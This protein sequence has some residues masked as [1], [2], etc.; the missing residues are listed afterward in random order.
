MYTSAAASWAA[1]AASEAVAM[2]V[3][4]AKEL[5]VAVTEVTAMVA[6]AGGGWIRRR[7]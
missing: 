3:A 7:R 1:P 2:V 4:V 5:E 6:V